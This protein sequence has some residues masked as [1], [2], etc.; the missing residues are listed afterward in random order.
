LTAGRWSQSARHA[1]EAAYCDELGVPHD[2]AFAAALDVC[3]LSS[4]FQWIG[5]NPAWQAPAQ[6]TNDWLGDAMAIADRLGW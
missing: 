6:H 2:A 3:R 4:C 1:I 5:W